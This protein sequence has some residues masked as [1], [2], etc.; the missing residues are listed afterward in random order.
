MK[1]LT[2]TGLTKLIQLIK[3]SFI[4]SS[5]VETTSEVTLATVATTGA[6]SDLSGK[7]TVDQTYDGTS[8]NAQSGVAVASA[9]SGKAN[10]NLSNISGTST[11]SIDGQWVYSVSTLANSVS[12]NNSSSE[13]TY[14]LSSYLPN[15]NYNYEV[16]FGVYATTSATSGK[17]I[18]VTLKTDI[19][20]GEFVPICQNRARTNASVDCRGSVVLPV[21]TGRSV[22]QY[23]TTSANADGTY[24]LAVYGYRRI[25]TNS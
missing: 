23:S 24:T 19:I 3:S 18:G 14:S 11:K 5:D 12:W 4:S 10:T 2:T 17:F 25:G 20:N 1:V 7:P 16:I 22:T 21:G 6:Y 8:A 13:T 9:I 15:D